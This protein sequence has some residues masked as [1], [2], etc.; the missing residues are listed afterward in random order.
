MKPEVLEAEIV[1][2]KVLPLFETKDAEFDGSAQV[3]LDDN[4]S[5][6]ANSIPAVFIEGLFGVAIAEIFQQLTL[7]HEGSDDGVI[8]ALSADQARVLSVIAFEEI[9]QVRHCLETKQDATMKPAHRFARQISE[10]FLKE[11]KTYEKG[12]M[13]AKTARHSAVQGAVKLIIRYLESVTIVLSD[14]SKIQDK[15][16]ELK[17]WQM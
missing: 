1:D 9:E 6:T 17:Q 12:L 14:Y 11:L 10:L 16:A 4:F 2:G 8:K 5:F 3:I 13:K 15:Q 7:F